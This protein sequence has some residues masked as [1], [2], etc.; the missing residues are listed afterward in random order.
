MIGSFG[1]VVFQVSSNSAKTISD[2][3]REC[4]ARFSEH[5]IAL[6]KPLLEFVGQGLDSITFSMRFDVSLGINPKVEIDTLRT[7]RDKGEAEQLIIGGI[8]LGL[9]VITGITESWKTINPAGVLTVATVSVSLKEYIE[10]G[11]I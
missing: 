2:F 9:F 7:V 5:S 10:D 8:P 4:E 3:G 11:R 6:G 1:P